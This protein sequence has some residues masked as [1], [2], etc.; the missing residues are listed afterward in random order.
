[1]RQ[2]PVQLFKEYLREKDISPR[3]FSQISGMPETEV[4]GIL[5]GNL[6][7][8]NLRAHHLAVTL[9]TDVEIWLNG[10]NEKQKKGN[11]INGKPKRP[12]LIG[13]D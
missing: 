7:I 1:M 6:P 13:S 8:T 4:Q 11:P 12:S 3:K 5:E 9:D 10:D 2:S